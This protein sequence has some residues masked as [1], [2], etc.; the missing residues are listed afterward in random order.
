MFIA[1]LDRVNI[2]VAAI[3]MQESLGW[4]ETEKGLVLS[5]FFIGY[6]AMQIVGGVL[7]DKYGGKRVML[8]S[9][10][11]WSVFT[12]LT[13]IAASASFAMLILVRIGLGLG[14]APLSPA[15]LSLYGRWI[16]ENERSRAVAIYS[17][18]A[19]AGTIGA[20][21]ITGFAV[22]K[23]GWQ[24]IF[25]VFGAVGLIYAMWLQRHIHEGPESHP[26]ISAEEKALLASSTPTEARTAIPWRQLCT[27]PQV[28]ALLI[29]FFCTSWSLYVFLSWMP[30]YFASEH[31]LDISS[32]GVYT[33]APWAVMFIMMNV[34]GWIAD[35][36]IARNWDITTVRKLMQ[37]IG[38]L[39]SA[40][41][42]FITR[43]VTTPDMALL[44]LSGA[45]GLLA[46]AYSG[47]APN[48][49]DIAP[50]FGG[51]LFGV[52]NTLGTLPG[53]IGVA[54]AGWLVD[55][56]GSYDSVLLLAGVV[57][58]VGATVYI[59]MGTAKQLID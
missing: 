13:P 25:Y 54:T 50:R 58:V 20:L 9:L 31:G 19:I 34:A 14:E 32:A 47:C 48:V 10:V 22:G 53:I 15:V 37:S 43:T 6:M 7:A 28:W 33:M 56:T 39:G 40:F 16:P 52:M 44:S 45:L 41:F 42:L 18:A 21:V 11:A 36:L 30:S 5:S 24:A 38:L 46:F 12:V 3:A 8:W 1:Y 4:S 59:L 17:S 51:V 23:F 49:L 57:S 29:T 27:L 55:T 35:S 26:R 2:S